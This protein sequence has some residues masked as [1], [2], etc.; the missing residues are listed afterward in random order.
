MKN[1]YNNPTAML[2]GQVLAKMDDLKDIMATNIDKILQRGERLDIMIDKTADLTATATVCFFNN[3]NIP[4]YLIDQY[5][6]ESF[7]SSSG[8][9]LE[10]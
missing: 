10:K 3:N 9:M 6:V 5:M 8:M 2:S 1:R 7:I 4:F